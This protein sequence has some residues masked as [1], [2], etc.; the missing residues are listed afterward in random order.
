[1][2]TRHILYATIHILHTEAKLYFAVRMYIVVVV[3]V[4]ELHIEYY[5][6]LEFAF[7]IYAMNRTRRPP[8]ICIWF[9]CIWH[10][11]VSRNISIS[12]LCM[13]KKFSYIC[14]I[15]HKRKCKKF[16]AVP[17]NIHGMYTL[18]IIWYYMYT[19]YIVYNVRRLLY[20]I[21]KYIHLL[22]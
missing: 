21:Y 6:C 14:V 20:I 10:F 16:F 18:H 8:Y 3:V 7:Y 5:S 11:R 4:F 17:Y 15:Y 22:M 19:V 2:Y 1:M 13:H 9:M 12:I